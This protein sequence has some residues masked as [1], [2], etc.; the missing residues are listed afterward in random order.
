MKVSEF[1]SFLIK[2]ERFFPN[3]FSRPSFLDN[4]DMNRFYF[5]AGHNRQKLKLAALCQFTLRAHPSFTTARGGR[6]AGNGDG[7]AKQPGD[8]GKSSANVV[9]RR[10]GC[11]N[12]VTISAGSSNCGEAHPALWHGRSH[13]IQA[14]D[15]TLVYARCN[16]T[17]TVWVALNVS[18]VAREVNG[19]SPNSATHLQPSTLVR[20]CSH[21]PHRKCLT[22]QPDSL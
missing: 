14:D 6:A 2:H 4:H 15:H 3:S 9:G 10:A 1:A 21:H 16:D 12:C 20:R 11:T 13:I 7:R 19:R 22:G 18:N 5:S 17:E 8:G